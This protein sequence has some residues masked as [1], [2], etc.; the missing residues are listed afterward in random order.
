MVRVA[1]KWWRLGLRISFSTALSLRDFNDI[2]RASY[3]SF[4][5]LLLFQ[6]IIPIFTHGSSETK[7]QPRG[8]AI[9]GWNEPPSTAVSSTM[10]FWEKMT[11]IAFS[12]SL[13]KMVSLVHTTGGLSISNDAKQR[14]LPKPLELL[15]CGLRDSLGNGFPVTSPKYI[16]VTYFLPVPPPTLQNHFSAFRVHF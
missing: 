15:F 12:P 2:P 3:S 14:I 13:P 6:V 4:L 1:S 7:P 8:S 11:P 16:P 10:H 5:I 9:W